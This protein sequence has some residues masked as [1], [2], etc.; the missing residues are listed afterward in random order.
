MRCI[1]EFFDRVNTFKCPKCDIN[2]T[3]KKVFLFEFFICSKCNLL[4]I[5]CSECKYNTQNMKDN[6]TTDKINDGEEMVL[7]KFLG[8]DGNIC[9]DEFERMLRVNRAQ[10]SLEEDTFLENT[11]EPGYYLKLFKPF[12][13]YYPFEQ[14][15]S[16]EFIPFYVGDLD[17]FYLDNNFGLN[18]I[19]NIKM[20]LDFS[21]R[22]KIYWKCE[23]CS[24]MKRYS[25]KIF[26]SFS[27]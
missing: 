17:I 1:F 26:Y 12:K 6:E 19:S 15:L 18:E 11:N 8:T 23:L 13:K 10:E 3:F 5:P 9:H 24:G 20:K 4:Q 21:N 2:M 27:S 16:K 25:N 7:L 22:G 14:E